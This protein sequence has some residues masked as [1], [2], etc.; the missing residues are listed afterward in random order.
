[1]SIGLQD[2]PWMISVEFQG[3][4]KSESR[5]MNL[6]MRDGKC[7][8]FLVTYT[9]S[10]KG[11]YLYGFC[12]LNTQEYS[13][14]FFLW[15]VKNLNKSFWVHIDSFFQ[16]QAKWNK[17]CV[18]KDHVFGTWKTFSMCADSEVRRP[19]FKCLVLVLVRK[20]VELSTRS[21]NFSSLTCK[22]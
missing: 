3:P 18:T 1:M 13:F 6:R 9:I 7:A 10:P 19:S 4:V 12:V 20:L 2:W 8:V 5:W 22:M 11:K 16:K 14:F 21:P 15:R 17:K